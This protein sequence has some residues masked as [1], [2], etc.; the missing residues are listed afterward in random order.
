MDA[1]ALEANRALYSND[2]EG[3]VGGFREAARVSP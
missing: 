1:T 2:L 3:A